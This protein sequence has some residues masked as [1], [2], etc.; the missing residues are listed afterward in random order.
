MSLEYSIEYP[1]RMREEHDEQTLRS[2]GRTASLISR[3]IAESVD[4]E[5][6]PSPESVGFATRF[7]EEVVEAEKIAAFCRS[8]CPAYLEGR[9]AIGCLGR[10][11]YPIDARFE[12]FLA[13]RLQLCY[14]TADPL[15]WPRIMHVLT[16]AE[17]V[18][19]GE[20][21][22]ELRRI[23]T[24]DGL[25]FF[26]LRLPIALTRLAKNLT[27]D[28]V[29]DALAGFKSSGDGREGYQREIPVMALGDYGDFL[30]VLLAKDLTESEQE[31]M[32]N[33]SATYPQYLRLLNAVRVAED[34]GVRILIE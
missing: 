1:C 24:A 5:R 10:I 18:F 8:S 20:A 22:K 33:L 21:T 11:N 16:D 7:S 14:D 26:E 17:S 3:I 15:S 30:E 25:R 27:T 28:H 31:R 34:L 4:G 29:F 12:H 23:T 32:R 13:D 19:D 6:A 9:E 2:L